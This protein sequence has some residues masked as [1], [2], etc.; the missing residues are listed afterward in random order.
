[1]F[2]A[3]VVETPS[4]IS[5]IKSSAKYTVLTNSFVWMEYLEYV[6]MCY[7]PCCGRRKENMTAL[8]GTG[9]G[10]QVPPT[11]LVYLPRWGAVWGTVSHIVI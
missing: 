7:I 2:A 6:K 10:G 9:T 3:D 11:H 4:T 8:L 1:M 5:P